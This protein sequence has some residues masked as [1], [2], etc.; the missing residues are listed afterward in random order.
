MG[1][2]AYT[3]AIATGFGTAARPGD[4]FA[5]PSFLPAEL[6]RFVLDVQSLRMLHRLTD[7]EEPRSAFWPYPGTE[8]PSRPLCIGLL[9]DRDGALDV[10]IVRDRDDRRLYEASIYWHTHQPG[11]TEYEQELAS[12]EAW[13]TSLRA[14]ADYGTLLQ[15]GHQ[16]TFRFDDSYVAGITGRLG[17][18]APRIEHLGSSVEYVDA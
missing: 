9:A 5:S 17:F 14:G 7:G 2:Q 8:C 10:Q 16:N 11:S 15:L 12:D 1:G 3:G 6:D 13:R 18:G 4:P